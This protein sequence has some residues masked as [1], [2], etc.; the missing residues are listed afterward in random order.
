MV[1]DLSFS[2]SP[3][4]M[5]PCTVLSNTN[6]NSCCV[7]PGRRRWGFIYLASVGVFGIGWLMDSVRLPFLL[8]E[9]NAAR[10]AHQSAEEPDIDTNITPPADDYDD[11]NNSLTLDIPDNSNKYEETTANMDSNRTATKDAGA[12]GTTPKTEKTPSKQNERKQEEH[13]E[14]PDDQ[15]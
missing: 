14:K 2:I 3:K 1:A 7:L 13:A 11:D 10:V 8:K 9:V 4:W 6:S 12:G 15:N 5:K